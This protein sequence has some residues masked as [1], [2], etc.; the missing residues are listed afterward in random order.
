M[1]TTFSYAQA[2]RGKVSAPPPAPQSVA[3]QAASTTSSQ[4]QEAAGTSTSSAPPSNAPSTTS[5]DHDANETTP[6]Q[7]VQPDSTGKSDMETATQQSKE[8]D[9]SHTTTAAEASPLP[10]HDGKKNSTETS[11]HSTERRGK[12]PASSARAS[13]VSDN[14]KSRKGKKARGAEKDSEQDQANETEKERETQIP[15][16]QLSEAPIPTVNIWQQRAKEAQTKAVPAAPSRTTTKPSNNPSSNSADAKQRSVA[17]NASDATVVQS[18]SSSHVAKHQKR[19]NDATRDGNELPPRRT[20]PRGS[21]AGE[22]VAS[23]SLPTVAD[24]SSWPTPVS[25]ATPEH[26]SQDKSEKQVEND[27]SKEEP[28]PKSK[29]KWTSMPYVPTAVFETKFPERSARGSHRGGSRG[30]RES[31]IRGSHA[32]AASAVDRARPAAPVKLST[33]GPQEQANEAGPD[34]RSGSLPPHHAKR[35]S[36]DAST[37]RDGRKAPVEATMETAKS[38]A[39][40]IHLT[41]GTDESSK[42]SLGDSAFATLNQQ[43]VSSS[44]LGSVEERTEKST[45]LPGVPKDGAAHSAKESNYHGNGNGKPDG[46]AREQ[47]SRGGQRGRGGHTGGAN[48]QG[49]H[50]VHASYPPNGQPYPMQ[51]NMP[52]RQNPYPA[53]GPPQMAYGTSFP[54][55][56][57][58][59]HRSSNPR[60]NSNAASNYNRPSS[61]RNS[62]AAPIHSPANFQLD[63]SQQTTSGFP[64]QPN[65]YFEQGIMQMVGQQLAYYF[66]DANFIK[67]LWLRRHMDSQ[68]FVFLDVITNFKRMQELS[69]DTN[70]VR[71]VCLGHPDIELVIGGEDN[72]E[73]IRR[74]RDWESWV[75]P[76]GQRHQEVN[77][78]DGPASVYGYNHY[79][80]NPYPQA[81]MMPPYGMQSPSVFPPNGADAQFT[82]YMNG[83]HYQ[84]GMSS[85]MNGHSASGESQLSAAVP[86]FSPS[87]PEFSPGAGFNISDVGYKATPENLK[88]AVPTGKGLETEKAGNHNVGT[89]H[90]NGSHGETNQIFAEQPYINGVGGDHEAGG[91]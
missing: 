16:A 79:P 42:Q 49:H 71:A 63:P 20:A 62:R 55:Q 47:R 51:G 2:A 83:S 43:P 72:R 88:T 5:N 6:Q 84:H 80:F 17:S 39:A 75:L 66:S 67:D 74:R 8:S 68:G 45:S 58:S 7:S 9:S 11:T 57:S 34:G 76:R 85:G 1:S 37:S 38:T 81:P 13:D 60:N 65:Y 89:P 87:A 25:A 19:T 40:Q 3:S 29:T 69:P 14:R 10:I 70:L 18:E 48:G 78:D 33:N 41:N 15:K 21:R 73:R 27:E 91:H 77:F 36:V 90:V 59:G 28:K 44:A 26:G 22:K 31:G 86:E 12:A 23:G 82:P 24:A 35:G 61:G 64:G 50:H 52:P 54:P 46:T 53:S 4:S 56:V 32:G 30:G